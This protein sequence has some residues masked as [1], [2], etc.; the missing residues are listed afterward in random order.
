MTE[1]K[2]LLE[3][4]RHELVALSGLKAFDIHA[5]KTEKITCV[6]NKDLFELDFSKLIAKIDEELG[7]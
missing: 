5:D 6:W 4:I 7:E 2:Q 1:N 3:V